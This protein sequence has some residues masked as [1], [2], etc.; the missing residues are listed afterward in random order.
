MNEESERELLLAE[1][2]KLQDIIE[3]FDKRALT[4]K[5]WSFTIS[6][7]GIVT[8]Y[9][10]GSTSVLA[11]ATICSFFFWLVEGT[12]KVNQQCF[13]SR[14]WHIERAFREHEA[15]IPL[16][17]ATQW[18]SEYQNKKS[19]LYLWRVLWWSHVALPHVLLVIFGLVLL[20]S[21]QPNPSVV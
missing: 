19:F 14:V 7:A 20:L 1:H 2:L 17:I 5:A 9:V 10:E 16:Q 12:W 11:I 3:D 21:F 13:Y 15:V 8:S 18:S 4:I 6:A